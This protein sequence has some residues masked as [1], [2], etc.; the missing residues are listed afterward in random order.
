MQP[1]KSILR[2]HFGEGHSIRKTAM[3]SR[4]SFSA[5][6]DY[7]HR[8]KRAGFSWP[9]PTGITN[10]ELKARLFPNSGSIQLRHPVPDWAEVYAM[11]SR[12]GQ[13][14]Q[15]VHERYLAAHPGG[16]S[17]SRFCALYRCW[18]KRKKVVM[19]QT[20]VPGEKL[21]VDYAGKTMSYVD[22]NSGEPRVAQIF[23]ATM[24]FS[25]FTYVEASCDQKLHSWIY[26]HQR[27]LAFFGGVPQVIVCDNLKAAVRK[28]HRY[29]P[30]LNRTYEELGAH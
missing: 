2:Y 15:L 30:E 4:V 5:A 13:T 14:L 17:Y 9:L 6:R 3:Y 26:S 29:D 8:A 24:G 23:V 20:H 1:I 10:E 18:C 21:F 7:V 22:P 11:L 25:S 12:K 28:A 27:A 19:R 16:Y